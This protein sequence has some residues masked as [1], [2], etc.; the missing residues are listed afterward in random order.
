MLL[1]VIPDQRDE[2]RSG[3]VGSV[4][5]ILFPFKVDA[6]IED[7]GSRRCGHAFFIVPCPDRKVF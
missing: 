4:S 6:S 2:I 3:I 1:V 5:Y 7:A